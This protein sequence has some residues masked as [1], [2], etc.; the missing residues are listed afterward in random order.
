[1]QQPMQQVQSIP[2]Q[3]QPT[4][5]GQPL[6]PGQPMPIVKPRENLPPHNTVYVHNLNEKVKKEELKKSLYHVFSR[7]GK[8]LEIHAFKYNKLRGQ[9]WIIF[10]DVQSAVNAV[11]SM[12][13]FNFFGK[14]M[15]VNFARVKSDLISKKDGT[16]VHRPKRKAEKKS[17]SK[18]K[19]RA[20]AQSSSSRPETKT[21]SRSSGPAPPNRILFVENLPAQCNAMML[22][23]LF[24]QYEGY[25]E[26][27]L[28]EAKPGIAFVEF[29]DAY[30][31]GR[32]KETLQGFAITPTNQMKITFAKK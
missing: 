15:R 8:I 16:F 4:Q 24:E 7:Y 29:G 12:E 10:D 2:P 31:A 5:S 32:A 14:P 26:A 25:V 11:N 22:A 20:P 18:R 21:K 9:A 23:M 6:Q 27:R 28:V 1:M 17:K 3:P 19:R 13:N 30:Q